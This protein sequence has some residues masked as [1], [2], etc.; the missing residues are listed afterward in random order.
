M[1]L[2]RVPVVSMYYSESAN[3]RYRK[4]PMSL[5][6]R[7]APIARALL[8]LTSQG[9]LDIYM[10]IGILAAQGVKANELPTEVSPMCWISMPSDSSV[11]QIRPAVEHIREKREWAMMYMSEMLRLGK[12][13]GATGELKSRATSGF[14]VQAERTDL[15]N[16]MCATAGRLERVESEVLALAVS[17]Y[18]GKNVSPID[19]GYSVEYNKRFVLSSVDEVL[20]DAE[21]YFRLGIQDE[22]PTLTKTMVQRIAAA[23]LRPVDPRNAAIAE[24]LTAS[25]WDGIGDLESG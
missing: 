3:P 4:V 19:L 9:Q 25:S 18:V 15:D 2:G 10:A 23:V 22:S 17:R 13:G 12:V 14:Q 8:N 24:E 6:T 7:V 20:G 5:L 1:A 16:E 11:E 21:R